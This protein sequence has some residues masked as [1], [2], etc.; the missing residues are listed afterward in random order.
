MATG[1]GSGTFASMAKRLPYL[2][3][4]GVNTIWL[5]GYCQATDHFYGVWSVYAT[6]RPD[7][8]DADLGDE[9]AFKA[10]LDEAH[11]HGIKILLDVIS[12]G[13]LDASSLVSEHPEWFSSRS[14]GMTDYNYENV[15]FPRMVGG[16]FGLRTY[17]GSG[18]TASRGRHHLRDADLWD[19]IAAKCAAE[20]HE[21]WSCP[22]T[23][24]T[25]SASTTPWPSAPTL[26]R[27][28]RPTRSGS[29]RSR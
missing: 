1:D 22:S 10:L 26:P 18:S 5:A 4:L 27:T 2:Q 16:T 11:A 23:V 7:V 3:E 20:G 6:N 19:K 17:D 14:W 25:T 15:E 13:V 28:G 12:H 21:S 9:V 24:G 8:L 29:P